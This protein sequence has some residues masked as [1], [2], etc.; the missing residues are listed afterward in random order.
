MLTVPSAPIVAVISCSKLGEEPS[1]KAF[2]NSSQ[3]ET[4]TSAEFAAG[5]IKSVAASTN[6]K[7]FLFIP[8][9]FSIPKILIP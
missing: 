4:F 2:H 9:P 7:N 6:G 1:T 5:A 3:E 8:N